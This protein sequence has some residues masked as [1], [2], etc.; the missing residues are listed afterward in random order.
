MVTAQASGAAEEALALPPQQARLSSDARAISLPL[1]QTLACSARLL[2]V[3]QSFRAREQLELKVALG[4]QN[5]PGA[6]GQLPGCLPP[7]ASRELPQPARCMQK[8]SQGVP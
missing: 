2:A 3:G 7:K 5:S 6:P 1:V 8:F 4:K